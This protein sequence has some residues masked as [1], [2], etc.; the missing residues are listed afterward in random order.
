MNLRN[1]SCPIVDL[2]VPYC[3]NQNHVHIMCP[4]AQWIV[5]P[6][7][8]T[9]LIRHRCCRAPLDLR[10]L[11]RHWQALGRRDPQ[12]RQGQLRSETRQN[13]HVSVIT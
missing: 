1:L 3:C 2:P 9:G 13:R 4:L 7:P 5:S 11:V 6:L 12:N 10:Q 8:F